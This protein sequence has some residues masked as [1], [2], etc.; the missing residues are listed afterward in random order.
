[1][2]EEEVISDDYEGGDKKIDIK[3]QSSKVLD[4]KSSLAS[5]VNQDEEEEE[6]IENNMRSSIGQTRNQDRKAAGGGLP[7]VLAGRSPMKGKTAVAENKR[8]SNQTHKSRPS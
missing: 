3:N 8:A 5:A 4:K 6:Y 1:L 2:E 7:I